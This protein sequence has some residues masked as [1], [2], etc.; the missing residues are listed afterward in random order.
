MKY[1]VQ[2]AADGTWMIVGNEKGEEV[3]YIVDT[4][5]ATKADAKRELGSVAQSFEHY[6]RKL[7]A[8]RGNNA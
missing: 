8:R 5:Y 1:S 3:D 2:Q 7:E 6:L 4:G